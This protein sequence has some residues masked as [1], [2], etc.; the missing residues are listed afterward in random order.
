MKTGIS[1]GMGTRAISPLTGLVSI[2]QANTGAMWDFSASS[3]LFESADT[4]DL[5]EIGDGLQYVTQSAAGGAIPQAW[6]Q[7]TAATRPTLQAAYASY[8]GGDALLGDTN[9]R[10][11]FRNAAVGVFGASILIPTDPVAEQ[12]V[13]QWSLPASATGA[14]FVVSVRPTGVVR[15]AVRRLAA[16]GAT[17]CD[18][19]ASGYTVNTRASLIGVCNFLAGGAGA[20][21]LYVNGVE[22]ASQTLAGTGNSEDTASQ[23]SGLGANSGGASAFMTGRIYRACAYKGSAVPDAAQLASIHRGLSA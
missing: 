4:S 10:D 15:L 22:I 11:I 23:A 20:L 1:L 13:G 16:D 7:S 14:R 12:I 21:R 6:S 2:I 3:T 9:N 19:A 5:A 17:V 8:D 18:S